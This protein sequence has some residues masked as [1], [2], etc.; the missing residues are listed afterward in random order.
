M[1][2]KI[3]EAREKLESGVKAVIESGEFQDYL[4]FMGAFHRYSPNNVMMI[5]MQN[6]TATYVAGFRKWLELGR[7]V[8]KGEKGIAIIVP[9]MSKKKDANGEEITIPRFGVGYVFDVSQTDGDS[10]P[11]APG[12][13]FLEGDDENGAFD[14]MLKVAQR[15]TVNVRYEDAGDEDVHGWYEHRTGD[16]VVANHVKGI[17]RVSVLI[18][19]LAHALTPNIKELDRGAREAVAEGTAY[20]VNRYF[21]IDS[22]DQSFPYIAGWVKDYES[23]M[24]TMGAIHNLSESIIK[25]VEHVTGTKAEGRSIA[26]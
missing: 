22:G 14:V 3:N 25:D 8:R 13:A 12:V 4:K 21:G 26:A 10:L 6:P 2:V 16:V 18:H 1:S 9:M 24:Q 15:N 23:F 17:E 19:E 11:E 7:H 20:I 5:M